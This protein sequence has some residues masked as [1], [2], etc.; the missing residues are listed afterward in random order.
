MRVD[1][2]SIAFIATPAVRETWS[3]KQRWTNA[4]VALWDDNRVAGKPAFV[5]TNL[6]AGG[7]VAGD[8][9][10][11]IV[12]FWGDSIQLVVNPYTNALAG[13]ISF[14]VNALADVGTPRPEAFCISSGSAVQ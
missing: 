12:A 6:P 10:K 4:S 11:M 3:N 14:V 1:D 8:F 5:T 13:K 9:S 2:D 7:I